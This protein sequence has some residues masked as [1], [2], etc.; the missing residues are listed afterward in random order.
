MCY[1]AVLAP[2]R[3]T[4]SSSTATNQWS[5][6]I[7]NRNKFSKSNRN[8]FKQKGAYMINVS[9]LLILHQCF[10][11]NINFTSKNLTGN[12]RKPVKTITWKI[13]HRIHQGKEEHLG[14]KSTLLESSPL[15][16]ILRSFFHDKSYEL[17]NL[18]SFSQTAENTVQEYQ[19]KPKKDETKFSW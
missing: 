17:F 19:I 5:K 14:N 13:S 18:S 12:K 1:G 3:K 7:S 2:K 4:A 6:E 15:F 9:H 16:S 10:E 11:Y 8:S